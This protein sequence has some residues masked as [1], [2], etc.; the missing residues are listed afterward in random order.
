MSL[1]DELLRR[2]PALELLPPGCYVVGGA[3][4]DLL[5]GGDPIDVDVA[6]AEPFAVAGMTGS[7]VIPLG[8]QKHLNAWRVIADE[9]VYDFAGIEGGGIEHDLERRDYTVNAIAVDLSSGEL[10]DPLHGRADLSALLVRMVRPSNFDDDPLRTLRGV[11]LAVT[12]GLEIE[13]D[14]LEAIRAR[15]P[16][17]VDAAAE[18]VGLELAGTFSANAFRRAVELLRV[19]GLDEPLGLATG[20]F[21]ADDVTVAGAYA[22]LVRDPRAYA[23]RWRWSDALLRAVASLQR[24][25]D[26]HGPVALFHAGENLATQLPAVLRA[27]GRVASLDMPDFGLR[28][29]LD[30]GEIAALT[31]IGPGK[32][33]GEIKRGLLEAQIRGEVRSREDAE[34]FVTSRPDHWV[35]S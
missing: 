35:N 12:L 17:V 15:A 22:L 11:R 5:R 24:L 21:H 32:R 16:R 20:S 34:R 8:D 30:G 9:R 10:L 19:T 14:T 26:D 2:F 31:G 33:L 7:R 23:R 27:L 25:V 13:P 3:V 29:L 6:C 1:R 18:R 28:A 4:R